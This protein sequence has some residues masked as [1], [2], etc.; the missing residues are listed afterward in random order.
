[1]HLRG[2]VASLALLLIVGSSMRS[3]GALEPEPSS[4]P[5]VRSSLVSPPSDAARPVVAKLFGVSCVGTAGC[6]AVGDYQRPVERTGPMATEVLDGRGVDPTAILLPPSADPSGSALLASVSCSTMRQCVAVG[7]YTTS[8]SGTR[9]GPELPM[10]AISVG[11]RWQR[12]HAVTLPGDAARGAA[13]T[14]TLAAV[15]CRSTIDCVAVGSFRDRA[16]RGRAFRVAISPRPPSGAVS[17]GVE[18]PFAPL[19]TVLHAGGED[20]TL[21]GVS[22]WAPSDCVAVGA[23][24]VEGGGSVAVTQETRDA[25]WMPEVP[26]PLPPTANPATSTSALGAVSCPTPG[27]C[28]AIGSLQL[29]G[30]SASSGLVTTRVRAGWRSASLLTAAGHSVQLQSVGCVTGS[31]RCAATGYVLSYD[32]VTMTAS[33]TAVLTVGTV[34]SL[35]ALVDVRLPTPAGGAPNYRELVSIDCPRTISCV[36]V[37]AVSDVGGHVIAYSRPTVATV[38]P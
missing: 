20:A 23:V 28:V 12:A 16:G 2:L 34:A 36:A 3:A 29:G 21:S 35:P 32:D 17:R 10:V 7:T 15:T 31:S 30:S 38:T 19:T 11:G 4:S 33:T 25:R 37:G 13:A 18:L 22:C 26:A 27:R 5:T 14:G 9:P 6:W 24:S 8:G 1:M